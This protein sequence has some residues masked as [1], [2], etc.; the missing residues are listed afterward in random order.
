LLAALDQTI[1]NPAMPRIVKELQ[2]FSLYSWVTTAYLLTSTATSLIAGKLGDMFGR[3]TVLLSGVFIFLIG[4]ALSGASPSMFW[5]VMFRG[6]QGIGAGALQSNAFAIIAE[7]FPDSAKRARWQGF[8]AAAFGL[9][10]VIGPALGGYITDN[11]AWN[12][13]FY[14][15]L[16]VGLVAIFALI[17]TLPRSHASGRRKIDWWG[18]TLIIGS[19]VSILLALTWGGKK[20]PQGFAWDSPQILGLFAIGA[21]LTALFIYVE[22][23]VVE[24]ILPLGLFKYA[25]VRAVA[26]ISFTLGGVM[27]G[28]TLFI[29]LFMQVVLGQSASSAGAVSTPLALALVT[30]NI[31]TG[32][33]IGRVGILK[34]PFISGAIVTLIGVGLLTTLNA[35]SPVWVITLFLIVLGFGLGLIMPSMT[36]AVQET[37]SRRELGVGISSVQFFRSIGST[38]AVAVI[39]TIVT[40]NYV[41]EILADPSTKSLSPKLLEVIQEP[42]NLLDKQV[43]ASLPSSVVGAV[44]SSLVDA[45]HAG[46]YITAGIAFVTLIAALV[47]PNIRI[48]SDI[49][50]KKVA[51]AT[52][53]ETVTEKPTE[54]EVPLAH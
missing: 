4:S 13:V 21:I 25:S 47:I 29:Q 44:H 51:E 42:Q 9:S 43:A 3:K 20:E 7:L 22:T 16:P 14:V 19:V 52:A 34:L 40:N 24:P 45:I 18:A 2:G 1:V 41:S 26:V 30:A 37:V 8:I 38:V 31:L 46:F 27:L 49:K 54:I 35:D 33:F 12:W 6:L 48:K 5:L 23:K 36:I 32:Q 28:S 11:L 53:S 17:F 39:G 15:N 50:R 10:S